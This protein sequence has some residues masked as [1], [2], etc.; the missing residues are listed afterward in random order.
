MTLGCGTHCQ[1]FARM[2]AKT[3][4]VLM[5]DRAVS[6][7]W[8]FRLDSRLDSRLLVLNPAAEL[9]DA[10]P[11]TTTDDWLLEGDRLVPLP[12]TH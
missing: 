1:N 2:N 8:E 6:V 4:S 10:P 11:G 12:V 7:G 5:P 9:P 3:G